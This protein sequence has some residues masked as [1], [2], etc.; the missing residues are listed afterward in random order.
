MKAYILQEPGAPQNLQLQ[1]IDTP[2]PKPNE[3][4]VK[5]RA[6]SINPVDTKVR[7]GKALY[8]SL[9]EENPIIVGWDISGEVVA[10]GDDVK[11]FKVGDEVFGMVNFPGHGKAYAEYV[12]APESHLA[13]KPANISHGEA[14]AATLAAL[15]AWQVLVHQAGIKAGQRVLIH[16]AAGG[17]GHYAVQIANYYKAIVIGT[18]SEE[19]HEF[20]R[21]MGAVEQ[22]DY[23][24]YNVEDVVMDADIVLDSL[25]EENTRRS[26]ATLREGGTIVSILGGATEAVQA[27]AKKRNIEAKSYLVHSSGEDQTQLADLLRQGHLR[28]HVAHTFPFEEMAKAHEQV[29]TRKTRGKV[30]VI[31]D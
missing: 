29:E 25:G 18:A 5:V 12:A 7:E 20:L 9:K 19:N 10:V 1:E 15:T 3:V 14:A 28:S 8:N 17:V 6:I 23:H 11:Y 4:L 16:A 24:K 13:H 21:N 26:L 27:E 22:I 30:V 31:L 2:T